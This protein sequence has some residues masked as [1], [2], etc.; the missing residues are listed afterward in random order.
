MFAS[1]NIN[2]DVVFS[3]LQYIKSKWKYK[4][5]VCVSDTDAKRNLLRCASLF[6]LTLHYVFVCSADQDFKKKI[7]RYASKSNVIGDG[8][9]QYFI[10]WEAIITFCHTSLFISQ[11]N[12]QRTAY[13]NH[14]KYI[15]CVEFWGACYCFFFH[16]FE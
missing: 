5:S 12:D 8:N 11:A 7:N 6:V 15:H 1:S 10:H 4:S 9:V 14:D 2:V 16:F 13:A 3:L